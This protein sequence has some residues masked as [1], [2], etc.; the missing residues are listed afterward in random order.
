MSDLAEQFCDLCGQRIWTDYGD[1]TMSRHVAQS[2]ECDRTRIAD[3][4]RQLAAMTAERDRL[5][6]VAEAAKGV[7][8]ACHTE[9][10]HG[11]HWARCTMPELRTALA[12]LEAK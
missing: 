4:E 11:N 12:A 8:C 2:A 1:G 7:Q 5:L 10:T 6:A 9:L 3:L